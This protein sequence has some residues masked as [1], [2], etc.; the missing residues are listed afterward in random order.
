MVNIIRA[1]QHQRALSTVFGEIC[2]L[3][4]RS[5]GAGSFGVIDRKA[6]EEA[7]VAVTYAERPALVAEKLRNASN[8]NYFTQR[9]G[10]SA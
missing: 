8:V 5:A 2:D 10:H 9:F 6:L 4:L 3:H 1:D 7:D